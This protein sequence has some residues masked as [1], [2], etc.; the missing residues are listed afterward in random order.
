MLL[1]APGFIALSSPSYLLC[2]V[3][4]SSVPSS[5]RSLL[6]FSMSDSMSDESCAFQI[7]MPPPPK[8]SRY[9]IFLLTLGG[10]TVL[11]QL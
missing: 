7:C 3:L 10:H 11:F 9:P 2:L 1:V 6:R 8:R 4:L 5:K